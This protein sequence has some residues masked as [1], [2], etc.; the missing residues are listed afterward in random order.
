LFLVSRP[1]AALSDR[2]VPSGGSE[3]RGRSRICLRF[4][5]ST[6][7]IGLSVPPLFNQKHTFNLFDFL[8]EAFGHTW[9]LQ[10]LFV[11]H[12]P[13][14]EDFAAVRAH[15]LLYVLAD[16]AWAHNHAYLDDMIKRI[17]FQNIRT[18]TMNTVTTMHALR[19]DLDFLRAEVGQTL[20][21]AP[22]SL[23]NYYEQPESG[24][25][26]LLGTNETP[27]DALRRTA[28][29]ANVLDDFLTNSLNL[30]IAS[31]ALRDSRRAEML[32]WLAAV[33][34]PLSFVTGIF[35]MNL[36]ELN[37][38]ALPVWIC[39]EVLG[40]VL[41]VTLVLVV[42]YKWWE[43]YRDVISRRSRRGRETR[44]VVDEP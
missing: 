25:P 33:Y 20:R 39:L 8:K 35:G 44:G 43:K 13:V 15:P 4:N 2:L 12:P 32:T 40:V 17:S 21:H 36:R 38:S 5:H 7:R 11:T 41:L 31:I 37:E 42:I 29:D 9:P 19:E 27:L 34:V 24:D 10:C 3:Q 18:P 16:F 22:S 23:T 6:S 26:Q 14:T 1:P 28:D 30:L